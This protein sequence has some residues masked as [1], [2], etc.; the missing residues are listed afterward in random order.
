M[1]KTIHPDQTGFIRNRQGSDNVRRLFHIVDYAQN[2]KEPMLIISMDAERV[3]DRIE[4]SFLFQ[5]LE[6]INFG[7]RFIQYIKTLFKEPLRL[8]S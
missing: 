1:P 5:T 3:F 6:R 4:P 8:K 2:K 7:V